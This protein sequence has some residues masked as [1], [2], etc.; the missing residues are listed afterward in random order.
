MTDIYSVPPELKLG[1]QLTTR[2]PVADQ[3]RQRVEVEEILRRLRTQP[4][5]ILADEVGM[6]KTF[7]ALAVAYSI[8]VQSPKG[9]VIVMVPPNLVSKWE[10]DLKTFCDLYV[11]ERIPLQRGHSKTE[12]LN[13]RKYF[14]YDIARHSVELLKLLDD[15]P[16][17]RCK[18]ILLAQG[19]MSRS[20]SDKWVRLALIAEAL[21]RHGRGKASRLIQVK[22]QIHR[23]LGRL[24][25]AIGEERAH[26]WGE[27]L[28]KRLLKTD[29]E[30]WK[31]IY[32]RAVINDENRLKDDPVPKPVVRALD[33]IDLK[34]LA[35][36]LEQ[37]PVRAKGGDARVSD[38]LNE[39]RRA[40]KQV[41]AGLW[42]DLLARASWRSPLLVMDEAHHLK[43][44]ATSLARQ[45]QS[46]DLTQD[47]RTGDGAMAKAFDRMLFLTAT[48][49]QLGHNELVQVLNRFGD[50]KWDPR[51]L[52]ERDQFQNKLSELRKDL[53]ETQRCC[54]ALQRAWSRLR[55]EDVEDNVED[56]WARSST[57]PRDSLTNFPRAV[58][59]AFERAKVSRE[60]AE[61]VLQ[62]WIVRH[63]KGV[64]WIGTSIVRRS[65]R[66]GEAL[67]TDQDS[68]QGLSV[69]QG[70]LLPFF[71]AARSAVNPGKD[72]LGEALSSS[73]EAFRNTRNDRKTA[74]DDQADSTVEIA[75][76]SC[77][78][79]YLQ[80]F[81]QAI[82]HMG[83]SIHPKISATVKRVAD[84]WESGEKV[85]VFAF[86]RHT[87]RALRRHISN[88]IQKRIYQRAKRRLIEADAPTDDAAVDKLLQSIQRRFFDQSDTPGRQAVDRALE[89]LMNTRFEQLE[90]LPLPPEQQ[91][92]LMDVMRRFLRATTTLVCCFPIAEI[93]SIT[94]D[95]TVLNA[96]DYSDGSELTWRQKFEVFID[97]LITQCSANERTDFLSAAE[98]IQTGR[99]RVG[100]EEESSSEDPKS[101][102]TVPNVQVATGETKREARSRLMLAFNTPFFPDILVCSEV[103]GEGV[104]LQ[105]FC[106]HVIHH[107]LDWNPSQIEQ[108]TGRIDRLG[109]KAEGRH[110]IVVY[111]PY[112]SGAADERQY[113]VM[114]DREKWFRIVMGQEEVDRLI[115]RDSNASIPLPDSIASKLSFKLGLETS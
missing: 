98:G 105:R 25:W 101:M 109:C 103:M 13:G 21:R 53:D 38:R 63:N 115:P 96:L 6:G 19:A 8:A 110:S 108:R 74:K 7:V 41:E 31:E 100:D 42:K 43:N 87:C 52:G 22:E 32:N 26:D 14:P 33:R 65:R 60:Q 29:P 12:K 91:E 45:L 112:L 106:R 37:M 68:G 44:P 93:D 66:D 27:E 16:R 56:W 46:V 61:R 86:Y 99:I 92:L 10:K 30:A 79:W 85:L 88:E 111:V 71:L 114:S 35:N 67:L 70:Q 57:S 84:L 58:V 9:P 55:P 77:E 24:L 40:L 17:E 18:L 78:P 28:W 102:L 20:Q 47:L 64:Y 104:D 54:I 69:P 23:F 72:L 1:K 94:P 76:L 89:S 90:S 97:F 36:A 75:D 15:P 80:Q 81:D 39:A 48:P 5:L 49:F 62:P 11:P 82:V 34:P 107:D 59:D 95:Q 51:E 4:G 3:N 50:V 2:V 73:Y 83:G 113:R